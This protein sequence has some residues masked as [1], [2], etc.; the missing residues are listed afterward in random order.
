VVAPWAEP[1]IIGTRLIGVRNSGFRCEVAETGWVIRTSQT[2]ANVG[3]RT[4]HG[5]EFEISAIGCKIRWGRVSDSRFSHATH[6]KMRYE[7]FPFDNEWKWRFVD[8]NGEVCIRLFDH[9]VKT[10][11]TQSSRSA[12]DVAARS[13]S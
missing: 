12:D 11:A 5:R 2:G 9:S 8:R 13:L 4:L 7:I 3:L 10:G 1:G 6:P